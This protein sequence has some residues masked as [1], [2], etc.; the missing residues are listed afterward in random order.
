MVFTLYDKHF[1]IRRMKRKGADERTYAGCSG[2]L[3]SSKFALH[4]HGEN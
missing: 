4:L 2:Y 1:T 3:Y